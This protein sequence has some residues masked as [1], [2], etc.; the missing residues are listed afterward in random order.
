MIAGMNK[1]TV[2][3]LALTG[4]LGVTACSQVLDKP[5]LKN[6]VTANSAAAVH[7]RTNRLARE[8]SPYL[9]QHQSGAMRLSA[10]RGRKTSRS[11]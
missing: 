9:L 3:S 7:T 10:K 11:S 8:K 4:G 5:E 6:H 2:L 1:A